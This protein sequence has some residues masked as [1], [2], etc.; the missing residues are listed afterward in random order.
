L[1][2][3]L[4]YSKAEVSPT[5]HL[6]G[7]FEVNLEILD[8]TLFGLPFLVSFIQSW[9]NLFWT[10]GIPAGL[11]APWLIFLVFFPV[12]NPLAISCLGSDLHGSLKVNFLFVRADLEGCTFLGES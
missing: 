1:I 10:L 8:G 5:R 11:M 6:F 9:S 12:L 2:L 3:G 7:A 4:S